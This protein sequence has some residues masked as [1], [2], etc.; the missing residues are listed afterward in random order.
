MNKTTVIKKTCCRRKLPRG[1][2]PR[3]SQLLRIG[4]KDIAT[5]KKRVAHTLNYNPLTP[6][7]KAPTTPT[8]TNHPIAAASPLRGQMQDLSQ[9]RFSP[10]Q[11]RDPKTLHAAPTTQSTQTPIHSFINSR[12]RAKTSNCS[13]I[14]IKKSAVNSI[15]IWGILNRNR[16]CQ[17]C[18]WAM[19]P[20]C[21]IIGTRLR[22]CLSRRLAEGDILQA[23]SNEARLW[24]MRMWLIVPMAGTMVKEVKIMCLCRMMLI[25][26]TTNKINGNLASMKMKSSTLATEKTGQSQALK[27]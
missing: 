25:Q 11:N 17:T 7:S 21:Q 26:T 2:L 27:K 13:S 16:S 24:S 15:L 5:S 1:L 23:R 9:D 19:L 10:E 14:S 18:T 4:N 3:H 12:I 22:S 20:I 6:K 8:P